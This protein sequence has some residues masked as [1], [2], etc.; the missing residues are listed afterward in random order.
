[1]TDITRKITEQILAVPRGR[2]SSY[3]VIARKAGLANG[4]RQTVRV[5]HSL[6]EKYNLPWYRIIRSDGGI[7]LA[8]GAGRELQI[9]LLRREGVKV[10]ENGKIDMGKYAW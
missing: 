8:E 6:S 9:N 5:L 1:M 2:V 10:S 3:G 7:A 4:A